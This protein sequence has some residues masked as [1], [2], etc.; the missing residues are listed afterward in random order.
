MAAVSFTFVVFGHEG[1]GF[2]VFIGNHLG[3]SLI[4]PVVVTGA[5]HLVIQEGDFLLA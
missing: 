4:D 5:Q 3:A 2:A 1:D